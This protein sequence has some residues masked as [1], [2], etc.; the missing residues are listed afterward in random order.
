MA[1]RFIKKLGRIVKFFGLLHAPTSQRSKVFGSK[2]FS[3]SLAGIGAAPQESA[4]LFLELFF[5]RLRC[6][7]KKA[8]K[9]DGRFRENGLLFGGR[10]PHPPQAVPLPRWGRLMSRSAHFV[11]KFL[12]QTFFKKFGGGVRGR[13]PADTAFSFG[14][15]ISLHRKDIR[16]LGLREQIKFC[17][18]FVPTWVKRKS[19]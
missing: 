7:R 2:L 1:K 9:C 6:Q 10:S 4:F 11:S 16:K 8:A 14:A 5:L 18:H 13:A 17:F 3:K 19:G 15:D 12:I